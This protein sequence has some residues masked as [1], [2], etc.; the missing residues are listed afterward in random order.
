MKAPLSRSLARITAISASAWFAF[1]ACAPPASLPPPV[2]MAA[3]QSFEIGAAAE[4]GELFKRSD[5]AF[6]EQ[7]Y[8]AQAWLQF[9]TGD[10]TEA[11]IVL[12]LS[13]PGLYAGGGYFRYRPVHTEHF[14][15]GAQVEGGFLWASLGMPVAVSP[16]DNLW[17]YTEPAVG[18]N[19]LGLVQIPV[20]VSYE[21]AGHGMVDLEFGSFLGGGYVVETNYSSTGGY[22]PGYVSLGFAYRN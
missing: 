15:L 21:F 3:D 19:Q 22:L 11:G 2:P 12:A 10:P 9:R 7:T 14:T 6:D 16:M 5:P 17:F 13:K 1:W 8:G 4:T 20:G 18:F